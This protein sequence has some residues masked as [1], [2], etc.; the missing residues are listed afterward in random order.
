MDRD[1]SSDVC[2]SDLYLVLNL[3]FRYTFRILESEG[4]NVASLI[5]TKFGE[6]T[7]DELKALVAAGFVLFV[8]TLSVNMIASGIVNRSARAAA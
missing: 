5:A 8:L 2:S 7:P 4:G 1:W 3:N 6:A